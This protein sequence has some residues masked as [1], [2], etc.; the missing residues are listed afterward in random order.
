MLDL[1]YDELKRSYV[2]GTEVFS[3]IA[4][5]RL[6]KAKQT[7]RQIIELIRVYSRL[8]FL[9]ESTDRDLTM[10]AALYNIGK[11]SWTDN[12]MVTPADMLHHTELD[13]KSVVYGKSVSVRVDLGGC[14]IIKKKKKVTNNT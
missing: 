5:L 4:N 14:R 9:D 12:M 8:H 3:L 13:R 10:A 1:A 7:N 11:L 2:T 6:P